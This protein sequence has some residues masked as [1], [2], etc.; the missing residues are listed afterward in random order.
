MNYGSV[1]SGIEAATVAWHSL[2]WT[3][4]WFSEIEPFPCAML[5]HHYPDV[6]NLGDMT[7][8]KKRI[9]QGKVVAPDIVVGGPPCQAFSVAGL[10]DGLD[11]A[12]GQLT[13]EYVRLAD[14]ID[15]IRTRNKQQPAIYVY[16]NV[17]GILSDKTNAFGCL[18]AGL[19]GE[20]CELQPPGGRWANAGCVFGRKRAIA[21]RV[22]DAQ[23]VGLAQRRKRVFIVGSARKGFDPTKILFEFDG[24]R[25]DI[26]PS[27]EKREVIAGTLE[28]SIARSRGAGTSL[29]SLTVDST[30][31]CQG[32]GAYSESEIAGTLLKSGQDLGN[33]CEA[34]IADTK[35]KWPAEIASTLNASFGT[36]QGL[37]DQHI[38][39]GCPLFVPAPI[40]VHGTQDPCTSL[41]TAFALGRNN[42]GENVIA[43]SSK[44]LGQD[45]AVAYS[46]DSLASNSMKSSNPHS[47]RRVVDLSKTLDTTIP[48]PSKNQGGIAVLQPVAY[49]IPGNWIGRKP[50][51]GGNA[52]EPHLDRSPCLT[53][54]DRHGVATKTAVRRLTPRECERL[55]GFPDDYTL[56]PHGRVIRMEKLEDD[57]VKYLMRGGV[58]SFDDVCRA[59]SDSLRYKAIGNSMAVT[60]MKWV[61]ERIQNHLT[62]KKA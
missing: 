28:A 10:R 40:I 53:A 54:S 22:I 29:A 8:I 26:A 23:F 58:I 47:G 25:R 11:D 16:E 24:V 39:G 56:I 31:S 44:D 6:P 4:V 38:N 52:T 13:I 1:C 21:W 43:F 9:L 17:P 12:R 36:K 49:G 42:G 45:A 51:N 37:E 61:G 35:A 57:W 32:I 27:R 62:S 3:P 30:F 19:A 41:N 48:C 60:V 59:A 34:L 33:G 2:G 18:L 5:A 46:F 14:A 20:S 55:M 15:F 7:T 50:E